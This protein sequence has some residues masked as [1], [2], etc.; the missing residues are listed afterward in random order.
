MRVQGEFPLVKGEI[1]FKESQGQRSDLEELR[2]E[3][4]SSNCKLSSLLAS[5]EN[6]WKFE[7]QCRTL[8]EARNAETWGRKMR[9]VQVKCFFGATGTGK[10]RSALESADWADIY[11]ATHYNS[12]AF[13][14]YDAHDVLILDEFRGQLPV[15]QLLTMSDPYPCKLAARYADRQAAY[16]SLYLLSNDGPWDWYPSATEETKRALCRRFPEV[17]EFTSV[18]KSRVLEKEEVLERMLDSKLASAVVI[19]S[20]NLAR[21]CVHM[22]SCLHV[23]VRPHPLPKLPAPAWSLSPRRLLTA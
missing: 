9:D 18:G 21:L 1:D 12:G 11:R 3:I 14:G 19:K 4:M 5:N 2:E 16:T 17:R 7:R 8:I 13:D 20:S 6:A 23:N 15:S 22:K 10:T